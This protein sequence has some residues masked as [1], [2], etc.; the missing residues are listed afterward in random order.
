MASHLYVS[1]VDFFRSLGQWKRVWLN[2]RS[3]FDT[4]KQMLDETI[5]R[6]E[7]SPPHTQCI[8]NI[9]KK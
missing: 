2:R 5:N 6:N 4:K 3:I 8:V 1:K 9:V 7:I